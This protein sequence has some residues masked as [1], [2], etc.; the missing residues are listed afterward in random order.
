MKKGLVF[1]IV[2]VL[3]AAGGVAGAAYYYGQDHGLPQNVGVGGLQVGGQRPEAAMD[4]VRSRVAELE[5]TEVAALPPLTGSQSNAKPISRTLRELGMRVNADD[6]LSALERYQERGWWDRAMQRLQG[7][8]AVSYDVS[9]T[10]D[11]SVLERE[12]RKAWESAVD[13][14]G[15]DAKREITETDDVVYTPEVAGTALDVKQLA[16]QVKKLAPVDLSVGGGQGTGV[17]SHNLVLPIEK[18]IPDVTLAKLKEE[19]IDRKIAEFTTS[20]R[21]S[22]AGRSHNVTVAAKALNDTLLQP[23]EIFEYGK[24]VDKAEKQYGWR[25]APVIV[26]GKLTPGVGGGICQVSSTLY[27]AILQAG[28]DVVERRNHSL[29]VHYLP[30]GLDAT[31]ADGY[32][33]FR[34]RNSTGKQLLIRTVVQDK[35]VTVKLFGTLPDNVTYRTETEQIK[36]IQPNVKYVGNPNIA[37]GKEQRLQKGEPG[38]VVDTY[39]V[40]YVDGKQAARD[41]MPRSNY[42]PQ[43]ELIAVN[44][45]DAR[46]KPQDLTPPTPSVPGPV[47]PV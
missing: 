35:R 5:N 31:F 28:L 38:F 9:V 32:V 26:K 21:T 15:K 14:P 6:A 41:K 7:E 11:D 29:V 1:A 19:G 8:P 45:N 40:K 2:F 46:L 24:I 44:P 18:K 47:E 42:K 3:L 20:F 37:L 25:E 36:V 10:W 39:R 13:N 23:D 16:A 34:F 33:N 12:V 43:D 17:K 22:A 30:P 4:L 27:N